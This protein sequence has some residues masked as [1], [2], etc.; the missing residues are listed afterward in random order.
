MSTYVS[1]SMTNH[2]ANG[3]WSGVAELVAAWRFRYRT[4]HELAL[5]SERELH[6][7]GLSRGDIAAE[8]DKP[9][10]RA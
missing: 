5:W 3:F 4:R 2:H 8:I 9:F 1:S 10:W 6:D 7:L